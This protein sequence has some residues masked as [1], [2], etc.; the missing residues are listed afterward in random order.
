ML[1]G[2]PFQLTVC[3][4]HRWGIAV[5]LGIV[6]TGCFGSDNVARVS[7]TVTLDEKPLGGARVVFNP[8]A[9]GGESSAITDES[10]N[11]ELQ[12]TR[13]S[14]GAEIG[15]HLVRITTATRGDPDADPL[16]PRSP[17][18]LPKKYHA[19]SELTAKVEAGS[20]DID[21]DLEA[22]GSGSL[23]KQRQSK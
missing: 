22:A 8:T 16:Q 4:T 21:F 2:E 1:T 13:E 15:E 20:N 5:V 12:Y 11:Y 23:A 19:K 18:R 17:E 10:G 14:Q 9:P 7:G 6:L 3:K